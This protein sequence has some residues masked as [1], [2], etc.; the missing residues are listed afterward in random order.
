MI[1]LVT[2]IMILS[3]LVMPALGDEAIKRELVEQVSEIKLP[4]LARYQ[5]LDL[6]HKQILITLQTLPSDQITG[7]TRAWVNIAAGNNGI[8]KK[9]NS[10]NDLASKG[11]PRSHKTALTD[12]TRL[13]SDINSL[14]G[15][16][17]AKD[18]F[19][20]SYPKTALAQFF[21]D[22]GEYFEALAETEIDTRMEID[23]YEH[24]LTAYK[25]AEDITKTTYID[26]KVKK[27]KSE[28]QFDMEIVN[29]SSHIGEA[30]FE[31]A[32]YGFN[33]TSNPA[34]VATGILSARTAE[35]ELTTV[36]KLYLKHGDGRAV[37]IDEQL[38]EIDHIHTE[39]VDLFL[40]YASI[41][42]VFVIVVLVCVLSLLFRWTHAVDDTLLGD[43][44]IQ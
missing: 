7:D 10:I 37:Q 28:Y 23:Y 12:A 3:T 41:F 1:H 32:L 30:K 29:T 26:L 31:E 22:Q 16:S 36:H 43:E 19:I 4:V 39:L 17:Q 11:D 44:V 42:V 8:L 27:L 9:F 20:T 35:R 34:A 2:A 21:V 25:E 13:K 5:E 38:L 24:A 33:H 14:V 40:K 18:N 6:M 15:Y